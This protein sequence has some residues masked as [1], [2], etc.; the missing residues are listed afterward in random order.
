M[1]PYKLLFFCPSVIQDGNNHSISSK[2]DFFICVD[3]VM[4]YALIYVKE[5]NQSLHYNSH[6]HYHVNDHSRF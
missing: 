2:F 4:C 3:M 5:I 6:G 1:V